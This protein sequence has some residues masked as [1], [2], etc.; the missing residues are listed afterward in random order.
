MDRHLRGRDDRP[1]ATEAPPGASTHG[2]R[3]DADAST[4]AAADTEPDSATIAHAHAD[5]GSDAHADPDT[6]PDTGGDAGWRRL[7]A[8][9]NPERD[10]FA[11]ADTHGGAR[12][13]INQ[14]FRD[15]LHS[16]G[17][18]VHRRH[19]GGRRGRNADRHLDRAA[20]DQ[21][22]SSIA[23]Q[24]LPRP[25]MGFALPGSVRLERYAELVPA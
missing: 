23:I 8:Q 6:H 2:E 22:G 9:P 14:W 21:A 4:D 15:W 3:C 12:T 1:A 11:V 5:A 10:T 24:Q 18:A 7:L 20:D 25:P 13:R 16:P 19:R 17:D